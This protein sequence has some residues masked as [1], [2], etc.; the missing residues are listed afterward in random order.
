MNN[1]CQQACTAFRQIYY[2]YY[3]S[4][5]IFY[6]AGTHGTTLISHT[7]RYIY[8]YIYIYI[9]LYVCICMYILEF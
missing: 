9:C 2:Q 1:I 3:V 5:T 4:V 8:I 6:L 7:T